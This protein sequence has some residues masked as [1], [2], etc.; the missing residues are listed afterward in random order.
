MKESPNS[1]EGSIIGEPKSKNATL[2]INS[3]PK[4]G[5]KSAVLGQKRMQPEGESM[6]QEGKPERKN[7]RVTRS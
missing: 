4:T 5:K 2:K 3:D 6:P 7:C 1:V